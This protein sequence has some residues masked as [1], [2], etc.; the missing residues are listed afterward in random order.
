MYINGDCFK[1]KIFVTAHVDS[2]ELLDDEASIIYQYECENHQIEICTDENIIHS[3]NYPDNYF[4]SS[5]FYPNYEAYKGKFFDWDNPFVTQAFKAGASDTNIW[6]QI[7]LESLKAMDKYT[8]KGGGM[9]EK[10]FITSHYAAYSA[11]CVH[12][13]YLNNVELRRSLIRGPYKWDEARVVNFHYRA[14]KCFRI[15]PKSWV[16]SP[17]MTIKFEICNADFDKQ[18][19]IIPLG[20]GDGTIND[21][22][23]TASEVY[24]GDNYTEYYAVHLARKG[25]QR[26]DFSFQKPCWYIKD[27]DSWFLISLIKKS[28]IVA[29]GME[30]VEECNGIIEDF[31][32]IVTSSLKSINEEVNSPYMTFLN[33]SNIIYELP[34]ALVGLYI[35]IKPHTWVG[36][37]GMAFEVYGS[38]ESK[39]S[40]ELIHTKL[41]NCIQLS[42]SFDTYPFLNISMGIIEQKLQAMTYIE[43]SSHVVLTEVKITIEAGYD[44]PEYSISFLRAPNE[45][46]L[47]KY[48][49]ENVSS[50]ETILYLQRKQVFRKFRIGSLKSSVETLP[51]CLFVEAKGEVVESCPPS[52]AYYDNHCYYTL[53]GTIAGVEG[54][55]KACGKS[56]GEDIGFLAQ[57]SSAKEAL[58]AS[59]LIRDIN[60]IPYNTSIIGYYRNES[61]EVNPYYQSQNPSYKWE[62]L[63]GANTNFS[64]WTYDIKDIPTDKS[65]AMLNSFND[66]KWETT[67]CNKH[68]QYLCKFQYSPS[69]TGKKVLWEY[70]PETAYE[71][72]MVFGSFKVTSVTECMYRS[73]QLGGP[74]FSISSDGQNCKVP[75][76][77]NIKVD[78]ESNIWS[79][80]IFEDNCEY[81][82]IG[83]SAGLSLDNISV[84][85]TVQASAN[86]S[87][88]R[89]TN[90]LD[91]VVTG[92]YQIPNDYSTFITFDFKQQMKINR[93][94]I[95]TSGDPNVDYI[96]SFYLHYIQEDSLWQTARGKRGGKLIFKAAGKSN[97]EK[98][99]F[100]KPQ[101]YPYKLA[102]SLANF[103][104]SPLLK[105]EFYGCQKVQYLIPKED[106]GSLKSD[107][108]AFRISQL[109]VTSYRPENNS[110][111][112]IH[113]GCQS[114]YGSGDGS[115]STQ[116]LTT[117]DFWMYTLP[118][119][120]SLVGISTEGHCTEHNF[121]TSLIIKYK[122]SNSFADV[123]Y[124]KD[125]EQTK[126]F[127]IQEHSGRWYLGLVEPYPTSSSFA[128]QLA[129][130]QANRYAITM[131]LYL[132]QKNLGRLRLGPFTS[133]TVTFSSSTS[134]SRHKI[135]WIDYYSPWVHAD[136]DTS[137]WIR[138]DLT[139]LYLIQR[140]F[141]RDSRTFSTNDCKNYRI[142]IWQYKGDNKT[143]IPFTCSKFDSSRKKVTFFPHLLVNA[144]QFT[145]INDSIY[146]IL[147]VYGMRA[148]QCPPGAVRNFDKCYTITDVT[149]N[150]TRAENLCK[151]GFS[152]NGPGSLIM[153]KTSLER[154]FANMLLYYKGFKNAK[155]HVGMKKVS[156]G[157]YVWDDGET[158][159]NYI[160]RTYDYSINSDDG[161]CV[162]ASRFFNDV[163]CSTKAYTIC[164][165]PAQVVTSCHQVWSVRRGESTR[166]PSYSREM[167]DL[168]MCLGLCKDP[169]CKGVSYVPREY[170]LTTCRIFNSATPHEELVVNSGSSIVLFDYSCLS[171]GVHRL[172]PEGNE[173]ESNFGVTS[174]FYNAVTKN[175]YLD[176]SSMGNEGAT[177]LKDLPCFI[178]IEFKQTY[179]FFGF[180]THSTIGEGNDRHYTKK[181]YVQYQ[182]DRN[183]LWNFHKNEALNQVVDFVI[184]D[185]LNFHSYHELLPTRK[186]ISFRM[187]AEES[188]NNASLSLQIYG[189]KAIASGTI[190]KCSYRIGLEHSNVI[191]DHQ[192]YTNSTHTDPTTSLKDIRLNSNPSSKDSLGCWGPLVN[193]SAYV[194]IDLG[195]IFNVTGLISQSCS[196]LSNFVYKFR[197]SYR[198]DTREEWSEQTLS[199][200]KKYI[201]NAEYH[202]FFD[203]IRARYVR[204]QPLEYDV[205]NAFRIELLGCMDQAE[206]IRG[207]PFSLLHPK[208]I[209]VDSNIIGEVVAWEEIDHTTPL[210]CPNQTDKDLVLSIDFKEIYTITGFRVSTGKEGEV[211]FNLEYTFKVTEWK[212][213]N[214]GFD[215]II[216]S[217]SNIQ[218]IHF[219]R[220][221]ILRYLNLV[222]KNDNQFCFK[223][224]FNG[225]RSGPCP[226][227]FVEYGSS[228]INFLNRPSSKEGVQKV[229][230]G[231]NWYG[232]SSLVSP[233]TDQFFH[234]FLSSLSF[235]LS[236]TPF[237]GLNETAS[238]YYWDDGSVIPD[239]YEMVFKKPLSISGDCFVYNDGALDKRDCSLENGLVCETE[240]AAND[241]T[242]PL[243]MWTVRRH[244]APTDSQTFQNFTIVENT[245]YDCLKLCEE[246]TS[247]ECLSF[248]TDLAASECKIYADNTQNPQFQ[249]KT[250]PNLFFFEKLTQISC[251]PLI[252]SSAFGVMWNVSSEQSPTTSKLQLPF[253]KRSSTSGLYWQAE[254]SDSQPWLLVYFSSEITLTGIVLQGSGRTDEDNYITEFTI[255]K[256]MD[257]IDWKDIEPTSGN[258]NIFKGLTDPYFARVYLFTKRIKAKYLRMDIISFNGDAVVRFE[259]YGC[260]EIVMDCFLE[261]ESKLTSIYQFNT[262]CYNNWNV[263]G[264]QYTYV[265]SGNPPKWTKYANGLGNDNEYALG[266][267][268]LANMT[269]FR[270]YFLRIDM[271]S[272]DGQ[273]IHAEFKNILVLF[274]ITQFLLNVQ[275]FRSGKATDGNFIQ[276][277][278]FYTIDKDNNQGCSAKHKT[279]WWFPVDSCNSSSVVRGHS[280]FWSVKETAFNPASSFP[281]DKYFMR[282][283]SFNTFDVSKG[284]KA[285]QKT[286]ELG[287]VASLAVDGLSL[288]NALNG[289]CAMNELTSDPWWVVSLGKIF[290]I[291]YIV[292]WNRKDCCESDLSDF[293]V[294]AAKEFVNFTFSA[295]NFELCK[296]YT[297][298]VKSGESDSILCDKSSI[299]GSFIGVWMEGAN[300]RLTLCEV[301][302]YSKNSVGRIG[303]KELCESDDD[304]IEPLTICLPTTDP[305]T[306]ENIVYSCLCEEETIREDNQCKPYVD[307]GIKSMKRLDKKLTRETLELTTFEIVIENL[308]G[309]EIIQ[310][311]LPIVNFN[312]SLYLT[313]SDEKVSE[314]F[315]IQLPFE[316]I[317]EKLNGS[318]AMNNSV[319][320]PLQFN[321][322]LNIKNCSDVSYVCVTIDRSDYRLYKEIN[323]TNNKLCL[324]ASEFVE[325]RPDLDLLLKRL[326]WTSMEPV[327]RDL[328]YNHSIELTIES[329]P[330]NS[331]DIIQLYGER[332]NFDFEY[333]VSNQ[334]HLFNSTNPK[335][336]SI[337]LNID[338]KQKGL[339]S[340][341]EVKFLAKILV[342]LD[343]AACEQT[344]TI[345]CV[346]RKLSSTSSFQEQI[347]QND[348]L[349]IDISLL[350]NCTPD[351]EIKNT[352]TLL[353]SSLIRGYNQTL[354]GII[355]WENIDNKHSI[356]EIPTGR[357]NFNVTLTISDKNKK[358][359]TAAELDLLIY[360]FVNDSSLFI[361]EQ[362][363][364]DFNEEILIPRESCSNYKFLCVELRPALG[365]SYSLYNRND[366]NNNNIHISCLNLENIVE[367]VGLRISNLTFKIEDNN[368]FE[369]NKNTFSVIWDLGTDVNFTLNYGDN[370]IFFW[371]WY[372][373]GHI[374]SYSKIEKL[375]YNH[376]YFNY[377]IYN[378]TLTAWNEVDKEIIILTKKVEPI[379]KDYSII[380]NRYIPDEPPLRVTFLVDYLNEANSNTQDIYLSCS[381][382][383]GHNFT[384][385]KNGRIQ[386]A[387][388]FLIDYLYTIDVIDAESL[389]ICNNTISNITYSN[390]F[391]L[392]QNV[393][394]LEIGYDVVLWPSFVNVSLTLTLV[395]GS[396]VE[397]DISYGNGVMET[398]KVHQLYANRQPFVWNYSFPE[399]GNFLT[400]AIARN[401][402]FNTSAQASN[403]IKIQHEIQEVE[404]KVN[405]F[406]PRNITIQLRE[407][408]NTKIP[409][410]VTCFINYGDN[411]TVEKYD[412]VDLLNGMS[413]S[414]VY[415]R[416]YNERRKR[417]LTISAYC[418]NKLS[419]TNLSSN[420]VLDEEIRG[421]SI[422]TSKTIISTFEYFLINISIETGTKMNVTF[423]YANGN[424]LNFYEEG[425]GLFI[426]YNYTYKNDGVYT[427]KFN[428]TNSVNSMEI[429]HEPIT[430]QHRILNASFSLDYIEPRNFTVSIQQY[431]P[432][433]IPTN[434]TCITEIKNS[435]LDHVIYPNLVE[436]LLRNYSIERRFNE[437]RYKNVSV[438]SFC[439]NLVSNASFSQFVILRE[440][441][442]DLNFTCSTNVTIVNRT[443][444][445]FVSTKTGDDLK[446]E[447]DYGNSQQYIFNISN[448]Y[449][450]TIYNYSYPQV[451]N[452]TP[453][454]R[455]KN[456]VNELFEALPLPTITQIPA[457]TVN[458]SALSSTTLDEQPTNFSITVN[459]KRESATDVF[460]SYQLSESI[461]LAKFYYEPNL[462]TT[463]TVVRYYRYTRKDTGWRFSVN[464][465]C[466]NLVSSINSS[467]E[468]FVHEKIRN[469]RMTLKRAATVPFEN[470][471]IILWVDTGSLVTYSVQFDD[472][473][474]FT[475][476]HPKIFA[477]D[478]SFKF[479]FIFNKIGNYSVG[480]KAKNYVSEE[481]LLR[482]ISVQ[483]NIE[484]ITITANKSILWIPGVIDYVLTSK[485]DQKNL[486]DV[487]CSFN[488]SN[489]MTRYEY[490]PLWEPSTSFVYSQYFPRTAVGN[491]SSLITCYNLVS[492][493]NITRPT[494][495]ILDAVIIGSLK[496]NGTVLLTNRT[497]IITEIRRMGT[498]SCLIFDLD[499]NDKQLAYGVNEFCRNNIPGNISYQQIEYNQTLIIFDHIFSNIG[500]YNVTLTAFNLIT[501]DIRWFRSE[502]ADWYCNDPNA[503]IAQEFT[504]EQSFTTVMKS[505]ELYIPSLAEYNCTMSRQI[506]H[507][508][509]VYQL[510]SNKLLYSSDS[511]KFVLPPRTVDYGKYRVEYFISMLWHPIFNNSYTAYFEVVPTP[512]QLNLTNGKT[513]TAIY[514]TNVT[515]DAYTLSSDLD[516]DPSEKFKGVTFKWFCRQS[517]ENFPTTE[518]LRQLDPVN[519]PTFEEFQNNGGCFG[520]GSSLVYI[521]NNG[522][523]ILNTFFMLPNASYIIDVKMSSIYAN[524][525]KFFQIKFNIPP[526]K[527]PKLKLTCVDNCQEKKAFNAETKYEVECF[528]GC[529]SLYW[530]IIYEWKLLIRLNGLWF[531][532]RTNAIQKQAKRDSEIVF[533]AEEMAGG[534]YF[535]LSVKGSLEK[536]GE[537]ERVNETFL[538]NKPPFGGKCSRE[539]SEGYASIN[540]FDITCQ[541]WQEFEKPQFARDLK[542]VFRS[543]PKGV[544][545]SFLLYFALKNGAAS[546]L[547]SVGD[548]I[549]LITEVIIQI[550]DSVGDVYKFILDMKVMPPP[551]KEVD[552]LNLVNYLLN[553]K[554]ME[555]LLEAGNYTTIGPTLYSIASILN[556]N[557]NK[558]LENFENM[559]TNEMEEYRS[560]ITKFRKR[561]REKMVEIAIQLPYQSINE[562]EQSNSI[563]SAIVYKPKELNYKTLKMTSRQLLKL[564]D[565][566]HSS[567]AEREKNKEISI[568]LIETSIRLATSVE[569]Y[570]RDQES[571]YIESN[572]TTTNSTINNSTIDQDVQ[573][574]LQLKE[575]MRRII[576]TIDNITDSLLDTLKLNDTP[577]QV[578]FE[579]IFL[580]I[581]KTSPIELLRKNFTN[582]LGELNI[583]S[584]EIINYTCA[585]RK[586]V[587]T[588]FNLFMWDETSND[589]ESGLLQL[590][591]FPC[592]GAREVSRKRKKRSI[593][594]TPGNRFTFTSRMDEN[595]VETTQKINTTAL[596]ALHFFNI[597][598]DTNPIQLRFEPPEH[599]TL[600]VLVGIDQR[601]SIDKNNGSFIIPN[602]N[603][604]C[605]NENDIGYCNDLKRT[606]VLQSYF[607]TTLTVRVTIEKCINCTEEV[608]LYTLS[609]FNTSCRIWTGEKWIENKECI[610]EK[611]STSTKVR[612]TSNLFGSIGAGIDVLPNLI[613]FD[614]VF[615]DFASKLADNAAVFGTICALFVLYI[616]L[617]LLVK[618]MDKKDKLLWQ[619]LPLLDNF[620]GDK[621]EYEV[622]VFTGNE[623]NSGTISKVLFTT[624]GTECN[625]GRRRLVST[626]VTSF[627]SASVR[628][629]IMTTSH[630]L[631]SLVCIR[632][633]LEEMIFAED[634][635]DPWFLSR[636]V[637]IDRTSQA[638]YNFDCNQWLSHIHGD[639][640]VERIL[641]ATK[642][643]MTP[644]MNELFKRNFYRR[645]A[646]DHL[647]ISVGARRTKS[648]FTRL[649]RLGVCFVALFL[650]MI[651]SC[652]FYKDSSEEANQRAGLTLGPFSF[653]VRE[654][655]VGLASSAVVFPGLVLI[656]LLFNAKKWRKYTVPIGWCVAAIAALT[657]AFFTILY[658]IQW[659]KEK[660]LQWLLSFTMSFVYSIM[661]IQPVKVVFIA[662]LLTFLMKKDTDLTEYEENIGEMNKLEYKNL[663]HIPKELNIQQKIKETV[664]ET[665]KLKETKVV[666]DRMH[667]MV[668]I[669]VLHL[670]YTLFVV[671]ICYSNQNPSFYYQNKAIY[672]TLPKLSKVNSQANFWWW[673]E[674]IA[675]PGLYPRQ[676]YNSKN[677]S[678]YDMK[679]TSE[680]NHMRFSSV[681]LFQERVNPSKCRLPQQLQSIFNNY[682]CYKEM[683]DDNKFD[684]NSSFHW[685]DYSHSNNTHEAFIYSK[686]FN[687]YS[688]ALGEDFQYAKRLVK[689]LKKWKWTD[690]QTRIV[691]LD[692]TILNQE[693][694]SQVKWTFKMKA[695]G[696]V[697][698]V[699]RCDSLILYRYTGAGGLV[700]LIVEILSILMWIALVIRLVYRLIKYDEI[701]RIFQTLSLLFFA[702]SIILYIWRT[703]KGVNAVETVMNSRKTFTNLSPFFNSHYY[704]MVFIGFCAFFAQIH[705]L[706]LLK[707][708]RTVS[709]LIG[710]LNKSKGELGSIGFCCCI[711]FLGYACWGYIL[712]GP[713][714]EI[715]KSFK[716]TCY[717]LVDTVFGHLDFHLISE[718]AGLLG[719]IYIISYA[720][721]MMYLILNIFIST[722]NEF[723]SAVKVDKTVLSEDPKVFKYIVGEIKKIFQN[724]TT[725]IQIKN[726]DKEIRLYGALTNHIRGLENITTTNIRGP[727]IDS[728]LDLVEYI[729]TSDDMENDYIQQSATMDD[730]ELYN[731]LLIIFRIAD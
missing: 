151:T 651:A 426:T 622:H 77:Y 375:I 328:Q 504:D 674:D 461:E 61:N 587:M 580:E 418:H 193:N 394:G 532:N 197:I 467:R 576:F 689:N 274:K 416:A 531:E 672:D 272:K 171:D 96:D 42:A 20:M 543:R 107:N 356:V 391:L 308:H 526:P 233:K 620:K 339:E 335:W 547:L 46:M 626:G 479:N 559:T 667:N 4:A 13:M 562:L 480:I 327:Y 612:F 304:C 685:H 168:R 78:K 378:V 695:T 665:M 452:F 311:L 509:S 320:L 530:Q 223:L 313:N 634:P 616:P 370:E 75:T 334:Q 564:N 45:W 91:E 730:E 198:V 551:E 524:R 152:W 412:F 162:V 468:I 213:F 245:N 132:Q 401:R 558:S 297:Q 706:N 270:S 476:K 108:F 445:F 577:I 1:S 133:S 35:C 149:D 44:K 711:F 288:T 604:T 595:A 38:S 169:I 693:I 404:L 261:T 709:V 417:N 455:I 399:D 578:T 208:G 451:G 18:W 239:D 102:F 644:D 134:T 172:L 285:Y 155:Y 493:F 123:F 430:I 360:S 490:I 501:K 373:F 124:L 329:L 8:I 295:S 425:P 717:A 637:I 85:A 557:L 64:F 143:E 727:D 352:L 50:T 519:I 696:G 146:L 380:S 79:S 448:F 263:I 539:P 582:P 572:T 153:P 255:K 474:S 106:V 118:T 177:C 24:K 12:F 236:F 376:I 243:Y 705:L 257:N 553:A 459:D 230:E 673:I 441:V 703:V 385:N 661:L 442:T 653:T 715:Y 89:F 347:S 636:I 49:T 639:G 379:L 527:A 707:I 229:C 265:D 496:D 217:T 481:E 491:L 680:Y 597:S 419:Q 7:Q 720:S 219:G 514:D 323:E 581:G 92:F 503:T 167:H 435:T 565:A 65:C 290:T 607:N 60:N 100:I 660:S 544:K 215:Q 466:K 596:A 139:N 303:Y 103:S 386:Y 654:L 470:Q 145:F 247:F 342:E 224:T 37:G 262:K 221:I 242:M 289:E 185:E 209:R 383:T 659:G 434:V 548:P 395:N 214:G 70:L 682:N 540:K 528:V 618:R 331:Y 283:K 95:Q 729:L 340:R 387:K 688:I 409:T 512:L 406:P 392:Q 554:E 390:Q 472:L 99:V 275:E 443:V 189:K 174:K 396:D 724:R 350:K 291:D 677:M 163:D 377:S 483:N 413:V 343:R 178:Q 67:D 235:G 120:F 186:G 330:I 414:Y 222:L 298:T 140:V 80:Y 494:E 142:H 726:Y 444:N 293:K 205:K 686:K 631:G 122:L 407:V 184:Q 181:A 402:F 681:R 268:I 292:I 210:I 522:T 521:E 694:V 306:F 624:F 721:I 286:T 41:S 366:N 200:F 449:S 382:D 11:D 585:S 579:E 708:S 40:K 57:M 723:I 29:I 234:M 87:N 32:V 458:I 364:V 690:R 485:H 267:D 196:K 81:P 354:S 525:K 346:R 321:Y 372:N 357:F 59:N 33:E 86:L 450:T 697:T 341:K 583:H 112:D 117:D 71:S 34:K 561:I 669:I 728:F 69:S 98:D 207:P 115:F 125:G 716:F 176:Y 427:L 464:V 31:S 27:T 76:Q 566:L 301:K 613:D 58:F 68:H 633:W 495:I 588:R 623:K 22:Q 336:T 431:S 593:V 260:N 710:T 722:L 135:S 629:F 74:G 411:S 714:T 671:F 678:K 256:S 250:S 359:D 368:L 319:V 516:N 160:P 641:M 225:M 232:K 432:L 252:Q 130:K 645:M 507:K 374:Q 166:P 348:N 488:F 510:Q 296:H 249:L 322:S 410:N 574:R 571:F 338:D 397:Y 307:V 482:N 21:Y 536:V 656:T 144:I 337:L 190:K 676:Y 692:M 428:L 568:S 164:E 535:D 204:I 605:S 478:E 324:A 362:L 353:T 529:S 575:V 314:T 684:R 429:L 421:L 433:H 609:V 420:L 393:S 88:L 30:P 52:T 277:M 180:V 72:Y 614:T 492:S 704:F 701:P 534:H 281:V 349:C 602:V 23:I 473:A 725:D 365:S 56:F 147:M 439:S 590:D 273:H 702:C 650:S 73:L 280:A 508:W 635:F 589:V 94:A 573:K 457:Y 679:H 437:R 202:S 305:F 199:I 83:G 333:I 423:D 97:E 5:S 82:L 664:E 17:T 570:R 344:T 384:V 16:G 584:L 642:N 489:G 569:S 84:E 231:V 326:H 487:H 127:D 36:D 206:V 549:N 541:G 218:D 150:R 317:E 240:S 498:N 670:I 62:W 555:N 389:I 332:I 284:K 137:P 683:G 3:K 251:P 381:I 687:G 719:K 212:T 469:L 279:G 471:V 699:L 66:G 367:C 47:M 628:S 615:D 157:N 154:N 700:A 513:S 9:A 405:Y 621:F 63:H 675:L 520:R 276:P 302:I 591:I 462:T 497:T 173:T 259:L 192:I 14:I 10:H 244:V 6:F 511:S 258:G 560:N 300:R 646:D 114:I 663:D 248:T 361:G 598:D 105:L 54:L 408:K 403:L 355:Q 238:K 625:S 600:Q 269:G 201:Q 156:A 19:T 119:D 556:A 718:T 647:W 351:V 183:F 278:K 424:V 567:R 523:F 136:D 475:K 111:N 299:N 110:I 592:D 227:G 241:T 182:T 638:W 518:Q 415:N 220:P 158:V 619:P 264:Y 447:L 253:Y 533:K 15:M 282:M 121:L 594:N 454:I 294:G 603:R 611:E 93:L 617:A 312:I 446:V 477:S 546:L 237:I 161:S 179:E 662:F 25:S 545:P 440:E 436:G 28:V 731:E 499:D 505:K 2:A 550:I 358:N 698:T 165:T 542:Y 422:E 116:S 104:G 51:D 315:Q 515:F 141:L 369:G 658:S 538:V 601:P 649:Q 310:T 188:F 610:T 191:L 211:R 266:N 138:Y 486:T 216:N 400:T 484:N 537:I 552:I 652:M 691:T 325:C 246:E 126:I 460:C 666:E 438:T 648:K 131:E 363:K 655:Y 287:N 55:L 195:Y 502:V 606:I 316:S 608:L 586:I 465:T 345:L 226:S 101:L 713:N 563:L 109:A 90:E 39:D 318:L 309:K 187:V 388:P 632:I 26:K 712:L 599:L 271:W 128:F 129:N 630:Y 53:P 203:A 228:C 254:A 640:H 159:E 463:Q 148:D 517:N 500:K 453:T 627:D 456:T 668:K 371:N 113:H 398:V 43:Y 170:G 657:A 643:D 48:N 175:Y 506:L 194:E